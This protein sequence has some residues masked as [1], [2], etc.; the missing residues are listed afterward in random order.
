[1]L[2]TTITAAA[3]LFAKQS[4]EYGKEVIFLMLSTQISGALVS[5]AIFVRKNKTMRFAGLIT[6]RDVL[7]G[8]AAGT[9]GTLA[10]FTLLTAL[11]TGYISLVYVIHAHYILIPIILSVWMHN[12]HIDGRKL[13][14]IVVS[15][16][17]IILIYRA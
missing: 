3:L 1:M 10:Y 17:A 5:S 9:L 11:T 2:S 14:A 7:L 4:F 8:F 13:T 16:L 6:R 15:S 12:D